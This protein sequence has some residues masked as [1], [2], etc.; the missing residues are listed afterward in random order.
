MQK[1]LQKMTGDRN[2]FLSFITRTNIAYKMSLKVKQNEINPYDLILRCKLSPSR[3]P[4]IY[5]FPI[6]FFL[7]PLTFMSSWLN[8]RHTKF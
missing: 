3:D 1:N 4:T 7:M 6:I 5:D 8:F 2:S